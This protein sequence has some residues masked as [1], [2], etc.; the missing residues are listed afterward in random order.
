MFFFGIGSFL[1]KTNGKK[2]R[3]EVLDLCHGADVQGK[4]NPPP[5]SAET[6]PLSKAYLSLTS[7]I[8]RAAPNA[9]QIK[10]VTL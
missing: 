7:L 9:G 4:I 1:K 8:K 3:A 10:T 6:P 2:L 5:P